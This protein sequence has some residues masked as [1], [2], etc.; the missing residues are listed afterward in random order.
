MLDRARILGLIRHQGAM[1]L[2]DRVIDCSAQRIV[3]SSQSHL[4][5]ANPLCR[6]GR[7]STVCGVEYGLQAAASHGAL[8]GRVKQQGRLV[9]LRQVV[10][11]HPR[12]D[13]P[14]IAQLRAEAV[15]E[16]G[17]AVGVIYRFQLRAE[18]G[19][20]LAEGR[21]TIAFQRP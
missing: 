2:L 5:P 19:R 3:C 13:D 21:A 10:I 14:T 8:L 4:N 16:H 11:H 15:L 12:L 7:L 17:D 1:C 20:R 9:A 6:R 18:D